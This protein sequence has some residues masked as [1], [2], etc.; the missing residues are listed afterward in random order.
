MP[1]TLTREFGAAAEKYAEILQHSA[2]RDAGAHLD[3]GRAYDRTAAPDKAR[4]EYPRATELRPSEAAAWLKL[5]TLYSLAAPRKQADEAFAKGE[6]LYQANSNLE[7]L[8][9]IADQS[10]PVG[11]GRAARRW[12]R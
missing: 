5:A 8:T 7:G 6:E 10:D 4:Q 2:E 3:L 11:T 12:L 9:E 1:W